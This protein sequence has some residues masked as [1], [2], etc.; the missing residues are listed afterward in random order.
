MAGLLDALPFLSAAF[1]IP[2]FLPQIARLRRTG[3]AAGVSWP[4]AALT[5]VNNTAWL[6]YF[7]LGE[8]SCWLAFGVHESDS[9]LIALGCTGVTAGVLMLGRIAWTR[10]EAVPSSTSAPR[11]RVVRLYRCFRKPA[12]AS[13]TA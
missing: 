8:L 4:W 7:T 6:T 10:G 13:T 9:R 1:A 2:Q 5:A 11:R 12:E 3:D